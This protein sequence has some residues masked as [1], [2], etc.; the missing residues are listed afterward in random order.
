MNKKTRDKIIKEAEDAIVLPFAPCNISSAKGKKFKC[1]EIANALN[2]LIKTS[3]G[4]VGA[5]GTKMV[6]K[7]CGEFI[8]TNDRS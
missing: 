6:D 5:S 2:V 8:S 4:F 3:T 1:R 7:S